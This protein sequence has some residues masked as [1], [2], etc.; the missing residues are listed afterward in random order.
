[1]I[2]PAQLTRYLASPF[3]EVAELASEI[4]RLNTVSDAAKRVNAAFRALGVAES[5]RA[6]WT[7]QHECESA[8]L[9]LEEALTGSKQ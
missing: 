1:M 2:T 7:A 8:V 3:P 4:V 5:M 6:R 9:A